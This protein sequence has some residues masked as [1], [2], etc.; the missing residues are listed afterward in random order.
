MITL[1]ITVSMLL[2]FLL[3]PVYFR[4][5]KDSLVSDIYSKYRSLLDVERAK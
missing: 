2:L 3:R 4:H 1:W 5:A